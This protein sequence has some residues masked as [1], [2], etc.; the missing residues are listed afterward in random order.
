MKLL[1]TCANSFGEGT[2]L[3]RLNLMS[4][5]KEVGGVHRAA[6]LTGATVV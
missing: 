4:G 6:G 5:L 2:M 3:Q 1:V